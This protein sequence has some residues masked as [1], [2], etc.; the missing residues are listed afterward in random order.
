[1]I[2]ARNAH[3]RN[4]P[5]E[6]LSGVMKELREMRREMGELRA[7]QDT[8]Q[9]QQP[10]LADSTEAHAPVASTSSDDSPSLIAPDRN[11]IM[12]QRAVPS[13]ELPEIDIYTFAGHQ[14]A[15]LDALPMDVAKTSQPQTWLVIKLQAWMLYQW[16]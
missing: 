6:L 16:M 12:L 7:R 4:A 2:L 13:S 1:M 14:A 5:D 11:P 9:G 8:R 15:G 10:H 3:A